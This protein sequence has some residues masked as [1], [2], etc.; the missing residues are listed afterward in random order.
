MRMR[1]VLCVILGGGQGTRLYPLTKHRSK[2]AV[3][4]AGMFRLIDVPIS[5]CLNSEMRKIYI[6]TQFLAESLN[7]HV[8]RAYKLDSFTPGF[9]DIMAAEQ[10]LENTDWFQ[11][12]ADAVRR[13]MR[14]FNDPAIEYIMILSGDQL[15]KMD[16]REL[17]IFHVQNRAEAT[18]AC[19]LVPEEEIAGLG[20]M[21]ADKDNRITKFVEKPKDPK[22]VQGMHIMH[23]NRKHYLG[24]MGIYCFNAKI[25]RKILQDDPSPDFGKGIIPNSFSSYNTLAY[26]FDGYWCDIGTIESFYHANLE[27]ADTVPK[28]NMY[29]KSWPF[30]TRS[31][32]LAPA[33]LQNTKVHKSLIAEGALI[34]GAQIKGSIVGLRSIIRN[35]SNI[36][37][38]ILMGADYYETEEE[39]QMRELPK[40]V[41]FG[42]GKN[43]VI[44]KAIID[45]NVSFG[46][47]VQIINK[48]KHDDYEG[49]NYCIKNGIVIIEKNA[50]IPSG[51]II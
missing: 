39:A 22:L 7:K 48:D 18:I 16:L 41:R 17:L 37:D 8:S 25:L 15:Y 30:F 49:D 24:S 19:N 12:T 40:N 4:L 10:T 35:D 3:P 50:V 21:G 34:E 38:S 29:D 51:T 28:L 20:I 26:A 44:K 11:G 36:E 6:L 43:C 42:I 46:D 45:K 47:N 32:F 14:H 5:N 1:N 2:P 13:C 27:L 23:N 31:R 33:K 9:V